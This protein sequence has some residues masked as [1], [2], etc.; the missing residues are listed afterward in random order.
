MID[1]EVPHVAPDEFVVV[2]IGGPSQ[3]E[4]VLVHY[5]DGKWL[6]VDSCTYGG[7]NLPLDFFEKAHVDLNMVE[8]VVCSHWHDDHVSGLPEV[9][10]NCPKAYFRLPFISNMEVMPQY[11]VY[12]SEK[13][14]KENE[15]EAW[16][17]FQECL[18][19]LEHRTLDEGDDMALKDLNFASVEQSVVDYETHNTR[20]DI[21]AFSPSNEMCAR[22]GQMLANGDAD[23]CDFDDGDIDPNM[24]SITLGIKF[25]QNNRHL[26]LGADLECNRDRA[27]VCESCVGECDARHAIGMCNLK[28]NH[29]FE[30]LHQISYTKI[31]HHSSQTGYC[32]EYWDNYV[33]DD[34]IGVSTAF[35]SRGLP[36]KDMAYKYFKS[37]DQFF[38]TSRKSQKK[39][40]KDDIARVLGDNKFIT[41]MTQIDTTPGIV[42]T[43]Y[44][45]ETGDY[46]GT[47][48]YLNA[49]KVSRADLKYF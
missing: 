46:K 5:G 43:R 20:V 18:D 47:E 6:V 7:T 14:I 2:V 16:K 28:G 36:K 44:D 45:L 25:G 40:N 38:I 27:A 32:C 39:L 3:G 1:Y 19:V 24:C 11:F 29:H 13:S 33:S 17:T 26:F 31:N 48:L 34:C 12:K 49:F 22:F 42:V 41:K 9:L 21:K 8:H 23:N 10:A 30:A 37:N 15:C 4:S 35:T